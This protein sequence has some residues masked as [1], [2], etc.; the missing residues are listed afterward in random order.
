MSA[1]VNNNENTMGAERAGCGEQ[2]ASC[3]KS[4]KKKWARGGEC[5]AARTMD[6]AKITMANQSNNNP[7]QDPME[8]FACCSAPSRPSSE[9]ITF[10]C[11]QIVAD[12]A[13]GREREPF[14]GDTYSPATAGCASN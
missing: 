9:V 13:V 14:D 6:C 10:C 7:E 5:T 11:L 12:S 1:I 3:L 4:L 2:C 8:L